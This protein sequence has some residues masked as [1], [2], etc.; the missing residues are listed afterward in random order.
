MADVLHD[1][2]GLVALPEDELAAAEDRGGDDGDLVALVELDGRLEL[3][4]DVDAVAVVEDPGDGAHGG[5]LGD[6]GV[7]G[8]EAH[9]VGH[10]GLDLE[11]VLPEEVLAGDGDREDGEAGEDEGDEGADGEFGCEFSVLC[12]H[13]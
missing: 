6:D 4:L 1:G 8:P 9:R 5:A 2:G 11:D 3:R 7:V 13:G 12:G 10:H